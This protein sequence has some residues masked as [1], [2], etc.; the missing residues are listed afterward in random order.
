MHNSV[1]QAFKKTL[2]TR[3][4]FPPVGD[5][6]LVSAI[7]LCSEFGKLTLAIGGGGAIRFFYSI[8]NFL[9]YKNNNCLLLRGKTITLQGN[10]VCMTSKI[11]IAK[12]E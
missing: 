7:T 9:Q 12:S 6:G 11:K 2:L 3:T 8:K 1:T 4:I 5:V 10:K